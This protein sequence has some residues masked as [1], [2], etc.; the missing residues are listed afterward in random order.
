MLKLT[1]ILLLSERHLQTTNA[2]VERARSALDVSASR[3]REAEMKLHQSVL[4]AAAMVQELVMDIN[5]HLHHHHP[6][7]FDNATRTQT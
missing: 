3:L 5:K 2:N 7:S 1:V 6:S 4:A